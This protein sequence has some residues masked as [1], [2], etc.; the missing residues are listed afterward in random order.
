MGTGK[1]LGVDGWHR[2]PDLSRVDI[3]PEVPSTSAD[4]AAIVASSQAWR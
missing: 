3:F 1:C 4:Q 2:V